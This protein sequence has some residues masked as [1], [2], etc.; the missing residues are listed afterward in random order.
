MSS[1]TFFCTMSLRFAVYFILRA[2]LNLE[3]NISL[4]ILGQNLDFIACELN[5]MKYLVPQLPYVR[6]CLVVSDSLWPFGL[7]PARLLCPWDFPGRKTGWGTTSSSRDLPD[8]G[9]KPTFPAWQLDSLPL[10]H[11]EDYLVNSKDVSGS[12]P[13]SQGSFP[14]QQGENWLFSSTTHY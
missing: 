8:P 6:A 4:E 1:F 3:V 10:S 13:V 7:Q 14:L 11:W 2:H 9:V 12:N 5:R